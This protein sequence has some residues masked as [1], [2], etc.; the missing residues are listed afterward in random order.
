MENTNRK[1]PE[2]TNPNDLFE[3]NL[4][5]GQ[6]GCHEVIRVPFGTF[7][8]T[9]ERLFL[10]QHGELLAFDLGDR[11]VARTEWLIS[12]PLGSIYGPGW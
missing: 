2:P 9:R 5:S 8:G 11:A 3:P 7:T 4:F 1:T 6:T 10:V 12:Y